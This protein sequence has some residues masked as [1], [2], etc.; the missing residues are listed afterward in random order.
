MPDI[1]TFELIFEDFK[2]DFDTSLR[3]DEHG[4]LDPNVQSCDINFGKSYFYHDNALVAIFM[5]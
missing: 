2:F 1:S 4:Y 5:H 3:L